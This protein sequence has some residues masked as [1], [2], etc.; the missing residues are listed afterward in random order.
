[1]RSIRCTDKAVGC[2]SYTKIK[3]LKPENDSG[4]K[5]SLSKFK[6]KIRA[7]ICSLLIFFLASSGLRKITLQPASI[8][9]IHFFLRGHSDESCNIMGT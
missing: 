3:I 5:Y 7:E 4:I 6:H 9:G 2:N 8:G 1:M